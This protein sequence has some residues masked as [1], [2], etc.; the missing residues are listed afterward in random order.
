MC[1]IY[2]YIYFFVKFV[3]NF[4]AIERNLKSLTSEL[5]NSRV[6]LGSLNTKKAAYDDKVERRN[7]LLKKS[8]KSWDI[9]Q[10][11]SSFEEKGYFIL[12]HLNNYFLLYN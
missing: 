3:D 4:E 8:L 2:V 10:I 5:D 6:K 12:F 1:Y 7:E 9:V 11:D